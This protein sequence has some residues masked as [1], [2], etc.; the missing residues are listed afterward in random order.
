M[1]FTLVG[2]LCL[3]ETPFRLEV[4]CVD[5]RLVPSPLV[6][7]ELLRLSPTVSGDYVGLTCAF[8]CWFVLREEFTLPGGLE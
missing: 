4:G 2:L 8:P 1:V 5:L 3:A 6:P 7:R